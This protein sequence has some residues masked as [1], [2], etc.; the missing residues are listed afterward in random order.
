MDRVKWKHHDTDHHSMIM[1]VFFIMR[2]SHSLGLHLR[3][4]D[5]ERLLGFRQGHQNNGPCKMGKKLLCHMAMGSFLPI[6]EVVIFLCCMFVASHLIEEQSRLGCS[7]PKHF[8]NT[9]I[10]GLRT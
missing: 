7:S 1:I 10:E 5:L 6:C 3:T 2:P 4:S 8:G 9:V